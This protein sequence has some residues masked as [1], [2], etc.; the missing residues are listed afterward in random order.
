MTVTRLW[1][2]MKLHAKLF[3]YRY[4]P[5]VRMRLNIHRYTRL[6]EAEVRKRIT[7]DTVFI[8]G[9]GY[10][11]NFLSAA[12]WR[13]I[14][15]HNTLSFNHFP[16]QTF[17]RNDFYVMRELGHH[18]LGAVTPLSD[19]VSQIKA[20]SRVL[21]SNPLHGNNV[22][23]THI[24]WQSYCPNIAFGYKFL[25]TQFPIFT[26][27][28]V[29]KGHKPEPP[30]WDFSQGVI[31]AGGSVMSC[32]H[33]CALL[34]WKNIVLLGIDGYDNR[35]F[36]QAADR[37]CYPLDEIFGICP[38]YRGDS[39]TADQPHPTVQ[40]RNLLG[41]VDLWRQEFERHG[42]QLYTGNPRSLLTK[43]LPVYSFP[44]DEQT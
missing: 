18:D 29:Q 20:F 37:F 30:T 6:T 31:K 2:A 33:V 21:N 28:T 39:D 32:I 26:F 44:A 16:V 24:E 40:T 13:Y 36:W 41:W 27:S 25:S 1:R 42:V 35:Y 11:L 14:E 17:V 34:G 9:S 12:Q 4:L 38:Q 43:H 23:L 15:K 22:I 5:W 19:M 3:P 7:S 10:S 8:L